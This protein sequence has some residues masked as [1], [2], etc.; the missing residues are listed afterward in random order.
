MNLTI[1]LHNQLKMA[2]NR[3][4]TTWDLPDCTYRRVLFYLLWMA[5]NH[6]SSTISLTEVFGF[7]NPA[8]REKMRFIYL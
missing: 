5:E 3:T 4:G 8:K 2:K 6:P 7:T 1:I